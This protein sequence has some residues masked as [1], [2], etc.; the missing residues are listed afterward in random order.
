MCDRNK[1]PSGNT[2]EERDFWDW[3][4]AAYANLLVDHDEVVFPVSF[5]WLV[6]DEGEVIYGFELL[7][8]DTLISTPSSGNPLGK[9]YEERL[10]WSWVRD[11]YYDVLGQVFFDRFRVERLKPV[12]TP[13]VGEEEWFYELLTG[14]WIK[15]V[16]VEELR[17]AEAVPLSTDDVVTGPKQIF[18]IQNQAPA[19]PDGPPAPFHFVGRIVLMGDKYVLAQE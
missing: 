16:P 8:D 9:T 2:G 10:F 15:P 6:C 11:V 13:G 3:V 19:K 5:E 18:Y 4:G 14:T 17:L 7:A 12:S 1:L